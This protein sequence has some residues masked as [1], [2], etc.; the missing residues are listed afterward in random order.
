MVETGQKKTYVYPSWY[1]SHTS[2][3]DEELT[4][5]LND[6]KL[7]VCKDEN[8]CYLTERNRL[9]NHLADPNRYSSEKARN[10]GVS[11]ED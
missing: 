8:G 7:V 9:D 2:M 11:H 10:L 6:E 5:D 4:A 3:I 1:G